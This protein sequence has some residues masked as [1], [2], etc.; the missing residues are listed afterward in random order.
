VRAAL[1]ESSEIAP[2]E[3]KTRKLNEKEHELLAV[4]YALQKFRVYIFG[5]KVT[6]YSDNKA[7]SFS[8][9]CSLTSNRVTRWIM[10]IQ[11]YDLDIVHIK[12]TDNFF[13]D[14]LSRNTVCIAEGE[15]RQV[16]KPKDIFVSAINP[17]LDPH[18]KRDLKDLAKHQL[19]DPKVREIRQSVEA[20]IPSR[21]DRFRIKDDVLYH[22]DDRSHPYWKPVLPRILECR[23]T[24]YPL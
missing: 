4:V 9:R 22:K 8:K 17:N 23:V 16:K 1:D 6:V 12:G 18:L 13:A 7:L 21:A 19:E 20:G 15:L 5:H 2:V 24:L 11:E 10:Q 14:T 3:A